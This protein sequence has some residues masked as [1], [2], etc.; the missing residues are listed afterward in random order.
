MANIVRWNPFREL[1]D[2]SS[3]LNRML[4]WPTIG[5]VGKESM[6]ASTWAPAVDIVETE[7]EYLV[8]AELPEVKKED[9]KVVAQNGVLSLTGERR[10]EKEE[11]GKKFHRIEREYGVFSRTFQLP[12]DVEDTKIAAEFKDGILQVHMPKSEKAKPRAVSIKVD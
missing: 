4:T 2:M 11:K 6:V 8:K 1:E 5:G 9:V 7:T 10:I 12:D 3:R